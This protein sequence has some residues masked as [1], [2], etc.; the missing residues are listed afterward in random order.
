MT[1]DDSV[2]G[3]QVVTK[4]WTGEKPRTTFIEVIEISKGRSQGLLLDILLPH[5]LTRDNP[6]F[7]GLPLLKG[8][9]YNVM[10]IE[11]KDRG[12]LSTRHRSCFVGRLLAIS[13]EGVGDVKLD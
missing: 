9:L 1:V 3:E 5:D 8:V 6:Q 12:N 13:R 4:E 2:L 10:W 7:L 11:W